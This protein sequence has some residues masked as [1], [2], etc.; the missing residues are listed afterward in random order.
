MLSSIP[1]HSDQ[2]K[3]TGKKSRDGKNIMKPQPVIDY[4]SAK[5]GVDMSDQM[6]SYHTALRKTKKW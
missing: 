6:A 2:F 5:K 3:A 4:S 1:E